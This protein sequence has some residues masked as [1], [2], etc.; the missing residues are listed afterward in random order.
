MGLFKIA[1]EV[2]AVELKEE[3][4]K[5]MLNVSPGD[6]VHPEFVFRYATPEVDD[7][8]LLTSFLVIGE[9]QL[10]PTMIKL[11]QNDRLQVVSIDRA[12]YIVKLLPLKMFDRERTGRSLNDWESHHGDSSY[13]VV[14]VNYALSHYGTLLDLKKL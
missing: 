2:A 1:V 10:S 8:D 12:K 13:S 14:K 5:L 6:I 11:N 9:Q 7:D 3:S 4:D